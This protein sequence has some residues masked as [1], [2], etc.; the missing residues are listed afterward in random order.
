MKKNGSYWLPTTQLAF[1]PV[2]TMVFL[3][4]WGLPI[5]LSAQFTYDITTITGANPTD[6]PVKILMLG[7]LGA[8]RQP[9]SLDVPRVDDFEKGATNQFTYVSDRDLGDITDI[10][11]Q[12]HPSDYWEVAQVVIKKRG[13]SVS[14]TWTAFRGEATISGKLSNSFRANGLSNP[15]VNVP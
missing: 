14:S 12:A 1:I 3:I 2:T 11:L 4:A 9:F 15:S 8:M 5:T 6:K 13:S 7:T 10:A